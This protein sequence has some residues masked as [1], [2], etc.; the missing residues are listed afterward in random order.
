MILLVLWAVLAS[1]CVGYGFVF[2]SFFRRW[3]LIDPADP[4]RGTDLMLLG[5]CSLVVWVQLAS[6]FWPAN[7]YLALLW[8]GG[9]A[10]IAIRFSE[11]IRP[12][13]RRFVR[14]QKQI[15][16]FWLIVAVV[17][18]YSTLEPTN[19]DSGMYH[20]P[21]IR[22]YERFRV[23]PGLGNLHG[24]LAFNSSFFVTSAAFGFTDWAGQTLFPL[25]GF[26]FLLV[27]WR[28]L[29][30]IRSAHSIRFLALIILVL[31]LFYL[32]RQVFS[33]TPDVWATLLPI[34][35]FLIWLELR[36]GLTV[37]HL[38]VGVLVCL[39]VTV[40]LATLPVAFCLLPIGWSVR[41]QL[42]VRHIGVFLALGLFMVVPWLIRTTI[43]SGYLF[44]PYPDLDLFS[45]DWKIPAKRVRFEKEFV[46]FWA[47]FRILEP[48]FDRSLLKVPADQ[49]IPGWWNH[50]EYYFLNKPTWVLAVVSPLIAISHFFFRDRWLRFRPLVLPYGVAFGGF[51]FW[52]ISAPEFRFGYP[53]IWLTALLPWLPFIPK[54]LRFWNLVPWSNAILATVLIALGGY[55]IFHYLVKAQFPVHRYAILPQPLT[56]RN[57]GAEAAY[58]LPHQTDSG[59]EVLTPRHGPL[60]QS[61]YDQEKPCSP[62]FYPD[63]ELRGQSVVEG[64]R[65]RLNDEKNIYGTPF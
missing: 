62:Y 26:L 21:S 8:V 40:K 22:W 60:Q 35:I 57:R 18:L 64:F 34:T 29:G 20:L 36:P 38:L 54:S 6:I 33:P 42:S 19:A 7:Q 31:L 1:G 30:L 28:L 4:V 17:L 5:L 15:S 55:F 24:R 10:L 3:G 53:Y 16:V 51:L 44:Y 23:I 59:L 47:R 56:Y 46:T 43:L 9:A 48:Y 32:I 12:Y 14:Q 39:C 11:S 58:F 37:S 52:F 13:I 41:R 27:C 45:F 2:Y 25:N 50:R 61:C 63:L 49:W 65:S